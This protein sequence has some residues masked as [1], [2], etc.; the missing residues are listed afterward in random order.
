MNRLNNNILFAFLLV[1]SIFWS[2]ADDDSFTLSSSNLLTMSVDTV[3]MDTVFSTV[4]TSTKTFWIYNQS[5]DG[6]RCPSVRLTRGNQSGF[7]VNIDG[8]Y[9]GESNGFQTSD[10]EVRD[11]DSIRV[12]VELTSKRN[13]ALQPQL[14]EDQLLFSLESGVEQRVT[15]QAHSWD[16][17]IY[18][19]ILITDDQTITTTRP[20]I[21]NKGITVR[22]GATL[23]ISSGSTLY[24]HSG[25]GIDVYGTLISEGT[26]DNNVCLRG[27]R[28]DNM[29]DYLPYDLVS[30]QWKGIVFH[31]T[32]FGNQLL[33]TDIHSTMDG[34]VCDSS[35]VQNIK[36]TV[37]NT[38]I[39]NCQGDGLR[40]TANKIILRN[41]QITNTLGHCLNI[42]GGDAEVQHC[43]L[44]QFYPFDADR[45]KA[46]NIFNEVNNPL[47]IKF[48]NSLITGYAE[49]VLNGDRKSEDAAFDYFFDTCIM[50]TPSVEDTTH[51]NAV[52][53]ELPEDTVTAGEKHFVLVDGDTQHYDFHLVESSTA[54]GKAN[55]LY[56]LPLD[57]E[58]RERN[59]DAACIGA[60]EYI[61]PKKE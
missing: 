34:V 2:C 43:T 19:E 61:K 54:V 26:A 14:V 59:K 44:A 25:A 5:G 4:P 40:S 48:Y 1:T 11:G 51:Y 35:S 28:T 39:H 15:L 50:R 57:R 53:W 45:G 12:F 29:F 55:P 24:F 8:I 33:Y 6:I 20:M 7:R 23:R 47:S 60:Y 17:D 52:I 13:G 58:G 32:S 36:L 16:A 10:I 38:T 42:I 18:D 46:L 41:T 27:D 37:E 9:L 30:G 21:I 22:E 56:A 3:N 49:D 31:D